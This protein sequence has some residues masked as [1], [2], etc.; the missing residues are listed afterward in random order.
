ML[1]V[2]KSL[3]IVC[4]CGLGDFFRHYFTAS[5]WKAARV[6]KE[7]HK[8]TT[9]KVISASAN[10]Q[11]APLLKQLS[12]IDEVIEYPWSCSPETRASFYNT[13]KNDYPLI[14]PNESQTR[15][16]RFQGALDKKVIRN[17]KVM[18][19]II[20][21]LAIH[22]RSPNTIESF[23]SASDKQYINSLDLKKFIMIHPFSGNPSLR[24]VEVEEYVPLI[25]ILIDELKYQVVVVGATNIKRETIYNEEHFNYNRPGLVN[26][27]NNKQTSIGCCAYLSQK[28]KIFIGTRSCFFNSAMA[29]QANK[30]ILL[31][32]EKQEKRFVSLTKRRW[33]N[34]RQ[35]IV[36][37]VSLGEN[38]DMIHEKIPLLLK[39]S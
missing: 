32:S 31:I 14:V 2:L 22:K 6:I 12:F 21:S 10:P 37:P 8:R 19:D 28:A 20:R 25:D 33:F 17:N 30:I 29:G 36:I 39:S 24:V 18:K 5:A 15:A 9:I 13:F 34:Y 3:C 16:R 35:P 11:T 38:L 26:L 4:D 23:L 1:Q 27:V 7:E